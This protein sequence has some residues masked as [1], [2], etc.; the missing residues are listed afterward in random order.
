MPS[1]DENARREIIRLPAIKG[2]VIDRRKLGHNQ[3][4]DYNRIDTVAYKQ[5]AVE[6]S[7][8]HS[9]TTC[10]YNQ[11]NGTAVIVVAIIIDDI[12]I[13]IFHRKQ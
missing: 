13:Y 11:P 5:S 3:V 12:L 4:K 8:E 9:A 2:H 7:T 1:A 10:L 6:S